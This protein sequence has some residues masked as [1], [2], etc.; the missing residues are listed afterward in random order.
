M[1]LKGV[2]PT[3]ACALVACIGNAHDFKKGRQLAAW[4]G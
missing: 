2:G 3:T 4:L 1:E